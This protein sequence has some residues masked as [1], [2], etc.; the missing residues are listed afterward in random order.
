[1]YLNNHTYYSMRLG[2]FS[3]LKL[4]EQADRFGV[5]QLVLSDINSTSGCINFVRKA[6]SY[7]IQPI[8]GIDF[9]NGIQQQYVGIAKNNQGFQDLNTHLSYHL[10]QEQPFSDTAEPTEDT[11]WVYPFAQLPKLEQKRWQDNEFIGICSRDIPKLRFSKYV[12]LRDR[13]VIQ[14][15]VTFRGQQDYNIHRLLRAIDTN[16]LLSKLHAKEQL[17]PQERMIATDQLLSE[18]EDFPECIQNTQRILDACTTPPIRFDFSEQRNANRKIFLNS[19]EE[20]DQKLKTLCEEG[21]AKRYPDASPV[22]KKRLE[23]ELQLIRQMKF[24]PYFLINWRICAYARSK[25]YY[26]VGRGSGA[27]SIVAYLLFITDVDPIDLDLYF[28]RFINLYRSTPPDFDIDFSWDDREDMTQFIFREFTTQNNVALLATYTTFQYRA[29]VRELGKVFGLPKHEIDAIADEKVLETQQGD[30]HQLIKK[31]GKLI[32]GKPNHLS[33]HAGG[34]LISEK[35]LHYYTATHLPPKGFPTVQFDMV[36]A[37]DVGLYKF[38]ILAQRGLGKIRDT[39]RMVREIYPNDNFD[40]HDIEAFKKDPNINNLIKRAT[41]IGCFYIESPAMRMLL[42][43]LEVDNYLGLVAASSI[44]R[45]GVAKSGMMREYILRHRH[46]ERRKDGHQ[47]MKEIMPDTYGIMVYQ[48]DVIKVAHHFAKLTLAEADVL[49]RGMSGKYRSREEFERVEQKYFSNCRE[50]GYD[51]DTS[52]EIW[53][54][55]RSFAGYA[56]AKGHS[57][58]YAV[59]SY[60]SL[61]LKAYYPLEYIVSILNNGGGF[62]KPEIYVHEAKMQGGIVELPCINYSHHHTTIQGKH[63]YLGM[64]YLRDL[65]IRVVEQIITNR[66]FEGHFRSF[67]DFLDRVSISLEQLTI[68]I[69]INAFRFTQKDKYELLWQAH[70]KLSPAKTEENQLRLFGSTFRNYTIPKLR[71]HFLEAAFDQMELLGFPLCS[72]FDLLAG[73]PVNTIGQKDLIKYRGSKVLIYGYLVVVKN[74]KTWNKKPM[75]FGTFLDQYGMFFDIVIFPPVTSATR[76]RGPGIYACYG[77][78]TEE[79]GFI[80]VE[81]ERMEKQAYI[82][83][84][85]Y[86]EPK[87][88]GSKLQAQANRILKSNAIEQRKKHG[89]L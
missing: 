60:Q 59:E 63:I 11:F 79:F 48:E 82:S 58:S 72:H 19:E 2:T 20:D 21:L 12:S 46:P 23:M 25:Q 33:I 34:I 10:C 80:S 65:E 51:F 14:Q 32:Q 9:R 6:P 40:I 28:E 1:M 70:F 45:P 69:R 24:V 86:S 66:N 83:D 35:P 43:K 13:F 15:P 55:I 75:H 26:Y 49:R 17:H 67:D 87:E 64:G 42:K 22:I 84:P 54:Q 76:F 41:C 57:A 52:R 30:I 16:T 7:N 37:E 74:T 39:V 47:V 3:E 89:Q 53:N 44:I 71:T 61:F 73:P 8:L 68:L 62:Y 38:D 29:V 5:R 88:Q 81:L 36:I 85:R 18:F 78:V 31:Y 77:Q 56:F 4:L 50:L 27:N